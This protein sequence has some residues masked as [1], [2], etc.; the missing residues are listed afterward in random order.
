MAALEMEAGDLELHW[1][2][3]FYEP[4]S[5]DVVPLKE[6]LP[7]TFSKSSR[8]ACIR[9]VRQPVLSLLKPLK[10]VAKSWLEVLMKSGETWKCF[11]IVSLYCSDIPDAKILYA[12]GM[13][14]GDS[15]PALVCRAC[16]RLW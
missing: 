11:P 3:S 13:K 7:Q 14:L 1:R 4:K 8:K 12:V 10:L 15:N 6:F 9:M 5:W 2:A 16:L